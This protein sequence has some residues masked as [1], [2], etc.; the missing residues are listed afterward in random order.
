VSN[1]ARPG[2]EALHNSAYWQQQPYIGIG[3][4]AHSFDGASRQW[5]IA[6]NKQYV[7][8]LTQERPF[9]ERETLTLTM[10]Y[11]E[12][13]LTGLRTAKG[14]SAANIRQQFGEDYADYFSQQA[15]PYLQT[16]KLVQQRGEGIYIPPPHFFVSDSII[17]SLFL[18]TD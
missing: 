7:A 18:T 11:N 15:K 16:G 6:N 17:G 12:Y 3:P 9:F 14:V 5:N 2:Y 8:A 1:F 4:S 10:R 13:I